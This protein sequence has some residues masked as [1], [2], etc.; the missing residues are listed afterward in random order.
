MVKVPAS[1]SASFRTPQRGGGP[2]SCLGEGGSQGSWPPQL[3]WC[4]VHYP[5]ADMEALAPHWT[6]SEACWCL[7]RGSLAKDKPTDSGSWEKS[8]NRTNAKKVLPRYI[9]KLQ[10]ENKQT[11]NLKSIN[12]HLSYSG[13]IIQ[14]TQISHQNPEVLGKY[15]KL[16]S[17]LEFFRVRHCMQTAQHRLTWPQCALRKC[18]RQS[19]TGDGAEDMR[20]LR[21]Y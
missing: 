17:F 5:E 6:R 16:P 9:T 19:H 4:G 14:I 21:L 12:S 10:T 7:V 11:K 2:C 15:S 1:H 3:C 20:E 13:K 18:L 8:N